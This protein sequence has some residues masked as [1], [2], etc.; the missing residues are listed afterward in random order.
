[1][2]TYSRHQGRI[3]E[4][5]FPVLEKYVRLV[6]F[7]YTSPKVNVVASKLGPR[8]EKIGSYGLKKKRFPKQLYLS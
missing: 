7:T 1:M 5:N 4:E 6:A 8:K 3:A 2:L